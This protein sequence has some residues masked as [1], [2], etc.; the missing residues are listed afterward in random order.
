MNEMNGIFHS[1][2]FWFLI[3]FFLGFIGAII[4][5]AVGRA[6]RAEEERKKRQKYLSS[7][8]MVSDVEDILGRKT[9]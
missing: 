3:G 7:K 8:Q 2:S 6:S 5:V 9:G 4:F 1:H